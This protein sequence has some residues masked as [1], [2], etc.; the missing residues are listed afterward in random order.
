MPNIILGLLYKLVWGARV[1]V[2]ID[3][4][5][6]TFV[7]A[8][9]PLDLAELLESGGKLPPFQGWD[10]GKWTRLAVGLARAFDGV[11]VANPALQERY[12]GVVIR[13]GRDEARFVPSDDRK[14][15]SRERFGIAQDKKVVLFF[16]TPKEY[17]GLVATA[18]ALGSLGRKDVVFAIIGDFPDGKLKEELQGIPGVDYVFVGNQP[19]ESIPDVVAVGDICVLLQDVGSE[20]S[21]FQIPAKLSDALGM[22]LVVL[23]SETAAVADVIESGAV[24]P[25][26]EGDL[27]AVLDRVLSDEAECNKFRVRGRELLAAEFGFGVNGSRLATVMDEVRSGVGVLSDELNLLL[28]GFPAVGSVWSGLVS[29]KTITKGQKIIVYTCNFGNYESV[30][31]P[32]AVDPRVEYILFT[33]R[34][35]I[36]SQTWKVV[37]IEDNLGDPRR[38]SRLPKILPHKYL[39]QHDISVYI[40]SSL[41]LKTP[42]VLK[43]VEECMEGH[44]IALY[45]HYKRNCVYDEINY[46][47][48]SKDR[49][50]VNKDL[51][52]RTI[53]KYKEI[54]YPKNNGL[55][56]NAFIFRSNTTPI[57][58]LNNLWWNDYEHGSERDQFTLMYAL[59]LTGIKPNTIKI[60]NQFRDNKYV[61]FYRHIYRQ[62]EGVYSKDSRQIKLPD[63]KQE[64]A[65][66]S[67][68]RYNRI[69]QSIYSDRITVV[70]F[71][72][73]D[74]LLT[75]RCLEPQDIFLY[76]AEDATVKRILNHIDFSFY[77]VLAEKS[78]RE[79]LTNQMVNQDPT[80]DNIYEE[81][82]SLLSLS[83]QDIEQLKK[84]EI[85]TE[86]QFISRRNS[87][88]R[89]Y[90]YAKSIGKKVI[91][92]SD[93]YLPRS[94]IIKMLTKC[95]YQPPFNLYIS[96]ESSATKKHGTIFSVIA[97]ELNV[98][99]GSILHI[100]DNLNSDIKMPQSVGC[101]ALRINDYRKILLNCLPDTLSGIIPPFQ[102]IKDIKSQPTRYNYA[103]LLERLLSDSLEGVANLE[104][105]SN[106]GYTVLGPFVLSLVLW[107]R[108]ISGQKGI[109]KVAWLAR[110]GYLPLQVCQVVDSVAGP[111]HESIYLPISRKVL[112]P[113]FLQLQGGIESIL[114]IG[115]THDLTVEK[116]VYERFGKV[117]LNIIKNS[118]GKHFE[119]ILS[120]LMIEHHEYVFSLLRNNVDSLKNETKY[121]YNNLINYYSK[122]LGNSERTALF[123][124]GR[125]GTFQSALS[126]ITGLSIHGFYIMN[127]YQI[128]QNAPGRNFDSYLGM[129]DKFARSHNPDTIIYEA[130]LSEKKPSFIGF[131]SVGNP[132]RE[133]PNN[134]DK[135]INQMFF[136]DLH[137][138]ALDF[139]KDAAKTFGERIIDLEQESFYSSYGLENWMHNESAKKILAN[140]PHED[141]VSTLN[142]RTFSEKSLTITQVDPYFAFAPKSYRQRIMIYCPAINRIRGGAERIAARLANYLIINGYE[143]LIFSSGNR[144]IKPHPVYPLSP[145]VIVRDVD[146]RNVEV[147]SQLVKSY[148]PSAALVLASGSVLVRI[149][150]AFLNNQVPYMLSERASPVFSMDTYWQGFDIEDYY[151][152][153]MA[154]TMVSVQFESFKTFFPHQLRDRIKVLPNPIQIP[155]QTKVV[156]EKVILCVARIWFKQK[157]QDILLKAFAKASVGRDDWKLKF[158]G[159]E[160]HNDGSK[161]KNLSEELG[162]TDKIEI[163][164]SIAN[165]DTQFAKASIFV[166]PSAFEGFPNSLAEALAYGIPSIGFKSCPGVNELIVDKHNGLLIDDVDLCQMNG[167]KKVIPTIDNKAVDDILVNR[168]YEGLTW[169]MDDDLFRSKAS[170]SAI[171]MIQPYQAELVLD[172]WKN[173]IE[174][175]CKSEGAL[176]LNHRVDALHKISLKLNNHIKK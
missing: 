128:Y 172:R 19:F 109:K 151:A 32:L 27:P 39:P 55:F 3:D 42:D 34:K 48:N 88:G 140:V 146:V 168:L 95:G 7:K 63:N 77:R 68:N 24:V 14:R 41:E 33:D 17:K 90:E 30:K 21:Q 56:E 160:Y 174:V 135:S 123:D 136:D 104:K 112:F 108:R 102:E 129:I 35:D 144:H 66:L 84:I 80:I 25:V 4:E 23:L 158:F 6:L 173:S 98:E 96:C 114:E 148:S 118:V 44:E 101:N 89:L 100:G 164:G 169:L 156:R 155:N 142:P 59:F 62:S 75:R 53:K 93:M 119:I 166:L 159:H 85:D 29:H 121:Q 20:V 149:S 69:A 43:M 117:G 167:G 176:L 9:E 87:L 157:R 113:Y 161:L 51:C 15:G 72:I 36:K 28:A 64:N 91:L 61:N 1:I 99:M 139:V 132:L 115:Y 5:E 153:Y 133:S 86:L 16:G 122:A 111:K 47:M 78:V 46:V 94:V 170:D 79:R 175:L 60:G 2:D 107:L 125:K 134:L 83:I 57:K 11:T 97:R 45:K 71:D 162:I 70:S 165:I 38:T 73:F 67:E 147:M 110:D 18:R 58:H 127:N 137:K 141:P 152:V 74:T 105:A 106:F 92:C 131:D 13:H 8:S 65:V 145:G 12:G 116:F 103:L 76:V 26:A 120:H 126:Q 82:G 10:G 22:G 54:N 138:G 163:H 154:A 49:V 130:L 40:D 124:V 37:N 150:Q 50:V 31:E 81:L 52:L 171:Q 143:V